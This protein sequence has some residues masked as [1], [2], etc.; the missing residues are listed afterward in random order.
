MR[1]YESGP[2][3]VLL[4]SLLAVLAAC[5]A[6]LTPEERMD[7]AREQM[8]GDDVA[9][10]AIHL[11]NVLQ[12]DPSNVEAR[13]L[14]AEASFR[15]AD[16][17]SA[18]KE[19]LRA[20]DLG[21]TV[22]EFRLPLVESLVRAGDPRQAL[23][24]TEPS[25]IGD[26][27]EYL[28]WRGLA[29]ARSGQPDAGRQL[30]ETLR[31]A[32]GIGGRAQVALAR[33]ALGQ[34][35]PAKALAMLA[36]LE[37][38]MA[39]DPDFW[40]VRAFAAMQMRDTELAVSAFDR[41]LAVLQD[42]LG[43]HRFVLLAGKT[44]AL[45]AGGRLDEARELSAAMYSQ[46]QRNQ[47]SNYLMS[48]V[49]LQSGN[50]AQA[51]AHAQAV[52]ATQPDSSVG[53]MM[54]GAA[55]MTLGLAVQAERHL[56]R[57]IASDPGNLQARKLL[58]QT[59]L[60]L[61]SPERALEALAPAVI[62]G[63][64][65]MVATLAGVASVRAGDPD[66][67]VD[68]FRRRLAADPQDDEARVML[69]VS[70]MSGGR[71]EEALAELGLVE[72]GAGV[73]RQR[74]DMIGIAAHL[75]SG[76][77]LEARALA[78]KVAAAAPGN[79]AMYNTLGA[80][81]HGENQLDEAAVW[82]EEGLKIA[83]ED[84]VSAYN[85]GRVRAAQ[86]QVPR[87][88]ELFEGVLAREPDHAVVL[89]AMAQIDW[90][91]G[92][93]DEAVDR[94]ERARRAD[95]AD[96]GSR[97]VLTQY[98]VSM[99]RAGAAA[100]VAREAVTI[101]PNSAPAV[102]ALGVALLE[103]GEAENAL[104]RFQRAH[105]INPVEAR[106]LLN[107]ARAHTALGDLEVAR[108]QLVNAL[109]LEPENTVML[110]GLVDLERRTGRYDAAGETLARLERATG[111][112][113][114]RVALLRGEVLLSQ[115]RYP[116]AEQAFQDAR[117][118]GMGSRAAVGMFE[119]RRLGGLAAPAEP[120]I[121]WLKDSPDD[122]VARGL[123]AEHY[124]SVDD[125]QAAIGEY[126]KLIALAPNNPLFLNNLAWLY[127]EIGDDRAVALARR[128]HEQAPENPSIADTYGWI[129]HRNGDHVGALELL[130]KAVAG[131]PQASDMRYRY[132]VV[133]AET[134]DES[135]A[136]R[137]AQAVLADTGAA[138]YHEPAQKLLERLG[139]GGE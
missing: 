78:A 4:V 73:M 8:A 99:G 105:E 70:L 58:A 17:D 129:L 81:F 130:A 14:L 86:G 88:V 38:R 112:G 133:L 85:L 20:I 51:L 47:V 87:A 69:A 115:Q 23:R 122:P 26:D 63:G 128:A 48:R 107:V 35:Q 125:R 98:L 132:A 67:A 83:P 137:E 65:S 123:L 116:A 34:Q 117:R 41:A 39:E 40:E 53:H 55:S 25:D 94:L 90:A 1:R 3:A 28:Y 19:Y 113:D 15:S 89:T 16:F 45:L 84:T 24:L 66:A 72:A 119:A 18:A 120:L 64:D 139:R 135:G 111:R 46:D 124:L 13:V 33:I 102:N 5:G 114:P 127:G 108:T 60:G 79:V 56:E 91:R 62:D 103:S 37:Q 22:D 106:Y 57:A 32:P 44:E 2:K 42:P 30:L 104:A 110:A 74:A 109:A 68:I 6:R 71:T 77:L 97:F 101:A 134:G 54:A 43:Q 36:P 96:G 61:Q 7:Q 21:A 76:D 82:Y 12:A 10:A 138:N 92:L 126:E 131:A 118:F 100:E 93:R 52:L 95:P 136:R 11:R 49:E 59:R 75:R 121:D 29:Y 27:P 50:A 31:D 80:L 9:T